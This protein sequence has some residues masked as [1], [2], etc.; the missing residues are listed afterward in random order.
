MA[1]TS[2]YDEWII[3]IVYP[4]LKS[5]RAF[6]GRLLFRCWRT[7]SVNDVTDMHRKK[8]QQ[9]KKTGYLCC[10]YCVCVVKG[11]SWHKP[12]GEAGRCCCVCTLNEPQSVTLT[13]LARLKQTGAQHDVMCISCKPALLNTTDHSF[14]EENQ[15]M[16]PEGCWAADIDSDA[17]I[18]LLLQHIQTCTLITHW[19][20]KA[21]NCSLLV[22]LYVFL[23]DS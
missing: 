5:C 19:C 21:L 16:R 13:R 20:V 3:K 4:C 7:A 6:E 10:M 23:S 11:E 12:R 8:Q 1:G 14:G 9:Q 22:Y 2:H 17:R 18:T 15:A